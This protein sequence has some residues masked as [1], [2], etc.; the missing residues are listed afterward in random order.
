MY[1]PLTFH[2]REWQYCN[3]LYIRLVFDI[4]RGNENVVYLHCIGGLYTGCSLTHGTNFDSL[5][6]NQNI[7]L[8]QE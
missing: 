4:P 6:R 2:R 1:S 8:F 5:Q 7:T 3:I